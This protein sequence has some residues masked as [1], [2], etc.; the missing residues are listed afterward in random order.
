MIHLESRFRKL[1]AGIEIRSR[2][3]A[4]GWQGRGVMVKKADLS[5]RAMSY[6]NS[7]GPHTVKMPILQKADDTNGRLRL[8]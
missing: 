5:D 8:Y 1:P 3:L 4:F 7:D 2:G 6:V